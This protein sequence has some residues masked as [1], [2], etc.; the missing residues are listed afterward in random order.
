[1]PI[2]GPASYVP[3]INQFI[4]HWGS[5]DAALG[6]SGPLVLTSGGTLAS[7][8]NYRD[9]LFG[10]GASIQDKLNDEQIGRQDVELKKAALL[11]RAG[12]FNRKVR[13]F[14]A[15]TVFGTAL[16]SIPSLTSAQGLILE[17][18]DDVRSLW[19][20]INAATIA[21]FTGPLTL[22]GGYALATFTTDL[23][24]M[25]TAYTTWQAAEQETSL[26]R[27]RRNDVQDLAYPVLRDYR[28]AVSGLFAEGDALVESLP[29]LSP[30]PGSTPD[31]V[32]ATA[33]W[34]AV[35][36]QG[37]L[38]W[39]ASADPNLSHYQIRFCAGATYATETESTIGTVQPTEALEFLTDAGL[40][41]SG[42]VAS[43]KV[44]VVLN[45]GNEKGSNAVTVTRP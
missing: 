7:L 5:V 22:L 25:K 38:T 31:P 35:P 28:G 20:K 12:E 16:P 43:F 34:D 4:P 45:T 36:L 11:A 13:G 1:M 39:T 32:T 17:P 19:T 40:T 37:K 21:G 3:T 15:Q 18:L 10:F 33:V 8:T 41:S 6:A 2:S 23:T 14:L 24:A 42:D 26:E 29:R 9:L 44:Y 30:E 27:Q